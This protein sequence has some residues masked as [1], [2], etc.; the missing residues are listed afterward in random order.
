MNN[1]PRSPR[2]DETSMPWCVHCG[3]DIDQNSLD[4]NSFPAK[5][6]HLC[7]KPLCD[8]TCEEWHLEKNCRERVMA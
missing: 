1:H 8:T 4:A 6:C 5:R 2:Q 7:H 3:I